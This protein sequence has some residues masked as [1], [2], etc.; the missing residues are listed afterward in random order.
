[1]KD[2][3]IAERLFVIGM[4]QRESLQFLRRRCQRDHIAVDAFV[5]QI[6]LVSIAQTL[7]PTAIHHRKGERVLTDLHSPKDWRP[8]CRAAV[9]TSS[10]V[11]ESS[12]PP[13]REDAL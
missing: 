8:P 7:K 12:T 6:E 13:K 11:R 4:F 3:H 1:M 10:R 2:R 5:F 9:A